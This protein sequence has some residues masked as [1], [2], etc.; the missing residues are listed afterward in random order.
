M[1]ATLDKGSIHFFAGQFICLLFSVSRLVDLVLLHVSVFV[2]F[3]ICMY[4]CL[5]FS[6]VCARFCTICVFFYF[7]CGGFSFVACICIF[8]IL[9]LHVFVFWFSYVCVL[10]FVLFVCFS[11]LCAAAAAGGLGF[12]ACICICVILYLHVFVFVFLLCVCSYL[13]YLCVFLFSVQRQ[14]D[15]VLWQRLLA[16]I[17]FFFHSHPHFLQNCIFSVF[18]K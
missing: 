4:L 11:I 16:L 7:L 6:H 14:V 17:T 5:Y 13:Y 15:L 10:V 1:I 3:C 8:V 2:W 9:Y 12:V 18:I